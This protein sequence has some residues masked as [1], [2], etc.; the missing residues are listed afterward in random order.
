MIGFS[1]NT[2]TRFYLILLAINPHYFFKIP[3]NQINFE[4]HHRPY[5][6]HFF[7]II[8]LNSLL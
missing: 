6:I 3:R 8:F 5:L 2:K 7:L 1:V 4:I